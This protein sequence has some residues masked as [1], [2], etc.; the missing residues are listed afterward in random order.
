MSRYDVVDEYIDPT[1]PIGVK[2]GNPA[3]FIYT[4]TGTQE[5]IFIDYTNGT[6]TNGTIFLKLSAGDVCTVQFSAG[7]DTYCTYLTIQNED[8]V[9]SVSKF[10][11]M[12]LV[13]TANTSTD[14]R[15]QL[16]V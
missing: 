8:T 1:T 6:S 11:K 9:L 5:A 3:E 10:A 13:I 4:G 12:R 15:L 14:I 2:V 16:M 7:G